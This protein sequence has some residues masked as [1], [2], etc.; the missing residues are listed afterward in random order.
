MPERISAPV[1]STR[2]PAV[3]H[4]RRR[5][6]RS[7]ARLLAALGLLGGAPLAYGQ[8]VCPDLVVAPATAT[9]LAGNTTLFTASY[10]PSNGNGGCVA[11]VD[12]TALAVWTSSVPATAAFSTANSPSLLTAVAPGATTVKASYTLPASG[13]VVSATAPVTVN[14][15]L[16]GTPGLTSNQKSVAQALDTVCQRL[17]VANAQTR[18]GLVGS[19]ADLLQ[20]C[21]GLLLEPNPANRAGAI[22]ALGAQNFTT[23]QTQALVFAQAHTV[24]VL[25]RMMALRAGARGLN[26]GDATIGTANG[27]VSVAQLLGIARD[28]LGG[29]ASADEPGGL[30][31]DKLGIWLRGNYGSGSKDASSA[32]DGFDGHQVT[33]TA[34]VDYR[35]GSQS[36]L[37]LALGMARSSLGYRTVGGGLDSKNFNASLYATSYLYKNLYLDGVANFGHTSYDTTRQIVVVESGMTI[38]RTALGSTGGTTWNGTLSLGYDF[39]AGGLTLTPMLGYAYGQTTIS[40]FTES[41]ASGF[42]LS[43]DQQSLKSSTVN[44]GLQMN[45]AW[46]TAIGVVLPHLRAQWIHEFESA[47]P[48]LGMHFAADPLGGSGSQIV[49]QGDPPNSSYWK[50]A[51]GTSIQFTHGVA[52]YV[53]YQRLAGY[54]PVHYGDVTAGL[55]F[56]TSF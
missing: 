5:A 31:S 19:Q 24:N 40:S 20:Q 3:A 38:D 49:V 50:L 48:L 11:P 47:A 37:G 53:E 2:A 18:G 17:A 1:V 43:I 12:V 14:P 46:N 39:V 4:R 28:V 36:V 30:L 51:A 54:G 44:A 9:L 23:F 33:A 34:G 21:S 6:L 52:G 10:S 25:D 42:D 13:L 7:L 55:R 26:L 41:G 8:A 22:A 32:D 45:F 15:P 35:L 29:G 27:Q 56:Q 16:A